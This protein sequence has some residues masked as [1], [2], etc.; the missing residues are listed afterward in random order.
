MPNHRRFFSVSIW[1]V[2]SLWAGL[3]M[4]V[5]SLLYA[6]AYFIRIPGFPETATFCKK[7][8]RFCGLGFSVYTL[9]CTAGISTTLSKK[10]LYVIWDVYWYIGFSVKA[11]TF[12][13]SLTSINSSSTSLL[14]IHYKSLRR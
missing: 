3:R 6:F 13:L 14:L 11:S 8:R 7:I 2:C 1:L 4:K 9:R 12:S 5:S 10:H